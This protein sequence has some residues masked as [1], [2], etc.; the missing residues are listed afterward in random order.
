[1][2]AWV[3][4]SYYRPVTLMAGRWVWSEN[5][6]SVVGTQYN[7]KSTIINMAKKL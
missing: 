6:T 5:H 4:L 3:T 7:F 1:M 2:P